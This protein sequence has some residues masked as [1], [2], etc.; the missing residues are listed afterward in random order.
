MAML[1]AVV[2]TGVLI[3]VTSTNVFA[4]EQTA[5]FQEVTTVVSEA[6]DVQ[7]LNADVEYCSLDDVVEEIRA[8]M[9]ARNTDFTVYAYTD[10]DGSMSD[11][12]IQSLWDDI[13]AKALS[14]TGDPKA[15]DYLEFHTNTTYRTMINH[16]D[17]KYLYCDI[18]FQN[19]YDTT[20]EQEAIMDAAVTELLAEMDL[21]DQT[22]F[23][24]ISRIYE[25]ITK[26]VAYDYAA[27][28]DPD[29]Y[30]RSPFSAYGALIEKSA[31]CEGY[32][33]LFYRLALEV[34]IDARYITGDA[35]G[36]HAW[37]IVKLND[38]YYNMDTTWDSIN[39]KQGVAYSYFLKGDTN[40]GDHTRD[41]IYQTSEFYEKYP[42][43]SE[44]Y[45]IYEGYEDYL[46]GDFH[47]LL[48][49]D[50]ALLFEY[51]GN[52][53]N[54]V[55][56]DAVAGRP[57]T[58]IGNMAFYNNVSIKSVVIPA[59]VT[60]I[61]GGY[62]IGSGSYYS[63]FSKC[64]SLEQVVIPA[65]S[66]L[67][68]I[69]AGTFAGCTALYD[70]EL[71]ASTRHLGAACFAYCES[72][73]QL[74]FPV[75]LQ[76]I[77][78]NAFSYSGLKSI[79]IPANCTEF[80]FA[81][82]LPNLEAFYVAEENPRYRVHEGVLYDN[83]PPTGKYTGWTLINY[84]IK[85]PDTSYRVPDYCTH[86]FGDSLAVDSFPTALET[87]YI[88]DAIGAPGSDGGDSIA[89][90][91]CRV[92]PSD[93]NEL[94]K[95][96]DGVLL[97]KD[98]KTLLQAP[99]EN[100]III[101]DSVTTIGEYV[102]WTNNDLTHIT[103]PASVDT[104][105]GAPFGDMDNL[106]WVCFKGD[107]PIYNDIPFWMT[108]TTIYFPAA[109]TTWDTSFFRNFQNYGGVINWLP[110]GETS[111]VCG[112]NLMWEITADGTLIIDGIGS[113]EIDTTA[114]Y[115]PWYSHGDNIQS[116]VVRSGIT[117]VGDNVLADIT[118][119][120]VMI[121]NDE[122][123]LS[124]NAIPY[125]DQTV[126][127][128]KLQS[129]AHNYAEKYGFQ[130]NEADT[131]CY[132]HDFGSY[133]VNDD[134]TC[135]SDGTKVARCKNC[136]FVKKTVI[137]PGSKADHIFTDYIFDNNAIDG[138]AGTKTA[139]CDFE[140]GTIDTQSVEGFE[141]HRFTNYVSDEN[142]ACD[143]EGTKTAYCDCGCGMKNVVK[144]IGSQL[145]HEFIRYDPNND[146]TCQKN[147]TEFGTCIR[148][149][150]YLYTREIPNSKVPHSFLEYVSNGDA[151]C[152]KNATG[153]AVCSFGCGTTDTCEIE[154]STVPHSFLVYNCN[155]DATCAKNATE[156]ASCTNDCGATDTREIEGSTLPHYFE[157]YVS[158][159]NATC[160]G[161]ATETAFCA[162]NCGAMDIREIENSTLPHTF[163]SFSVLTEAT[164]T[165]YATEISYCSNNCGA[166]HIRDIVNSIIPHRFEIY[167]N[168][169]D[170]TC[171]KNGTETA[172][173][174]YGCGAIDVK[175]IM[176]STIPHV[177]E[178]YTVNNDAWCQ[179]N[180]SE[181]AFCIYG[182]GTTDTRELPNTKLPH[183]FQNYVLNGDATCATNETET[184]HCVYGCGAEYTREVP[185]SMLAHRFI[186]YVFN[187]DATCQKNGTETAVCDYGCGTEDTREVPGSMLTHSFV[188]Y[189][190]NND[191][192][193]QK[194]GTETAVCTYGC[195]T[196]DIRELP[197]SKISHF[198]ENYFLNGDATCTTNETETSHCVYG[199]GA[200]DTRE[201]LES[202][203]THS[204]GEYV[205]N[206]DAT[207]QK[208]G[209]ETALCSHG[210]GAIDTREVPYSIGT[211]CFG[212]Y[213]SNNDATCQTNATG[214][215]VCLYDCG[216]IDTKEL[217][218][219]TVEHAFGDWI[220]ITEATYITTGLKT[221]KCNYIGCT[222]TEEQTID[223]VPVNLQQTY[224]GLDTI[225]GTVTMSGVPKGLTVLL[226]AYSN[227]RMVHIA[228]EV[229]VEPSFVF[230]L[231]STLVYDSLKVFYLFGD[232]WV[233]VGNYSNLLS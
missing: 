12:D 168:N 210:C 35:G 10:Y 33:K 219:T 36:P 65:S 181:T 192:T 123:L 27:V 22:D 32:A 126:I 96:V 8:N 61:K 218:N 191:A 129:T 166:A 15:G 208:N 201:V 171:V 62:H 204:F 18:R 154:N 43:A 2:L 20:P 30:D 60:V 11:A 134:A 56:P 31:V 72:L 133:V 46:E 94:Y 85:K 225:R 230:N 37:N 68:T 223:P 81:N 84:P 185:G 106:K 113:W 67:E 92:I 207:C 89:R 103:I 29:P 51:T 95:Y 28:A 69:G 128:A 162:N 108:S 150:G 4:E 124:E 202:M 109:N 180:N 58:A 54:V 71:P 170:A 130:F 73:H 153:T 116:V 6:S 19:S 53:T 144:D 9:I 227:G 104:I 228:C 179:K 174:E 147:G 149:C 148:N 120:W 216:T 90:L 48:S 70:I 220:T 197:D 55:I 80:T 3:S 99:H 183:L 164:C 105:N 64:T 158:N 189:I 151:T 86:I 97:S 188:E 63:A 91:E 198:F 184:S 23:E 87:I 175:E 233:P 136:Y 132:V 121:E 44:D 78:Q 127:H 138:Y 226:A 7:L 194:N 212:E 146:A 224:A 14:H 215:A 193:C 186:E 115:P 21:T 159:N 45:D 93:T 165:T 209:T 141:G 24:K 26:N 107:A 172:V 114:D 142:A 232:E 173:C 16:N 213:I 135:M 211:H 42:M 222:C 77:H 161:N 190:F 217:P 112:N 122:I 167:H 74:D 163:E 34:G 156:T 1:I 125:N 47:F 177:F 176:E 82:Y 152:T 59:P 119:S 98:G 157:T 57:V 155:N 83:M 187:D 182:C 41:S 195:G 137:N 75:E 102:F 66:Q 88:G 178:E 196:I 13:E 214:T 111:G 139:Q 101:P 79:T 39:S 38:R 160:M 231:P 221:R 145:G 205:F 17:G 169:D 200:E 50:E 143:K 229:N 199:C 131:R 100:G 49:S 5:V 52:E 206:N 110:Y 203:L 76:E 140:C 40:F 25:Y 117:S 118:L